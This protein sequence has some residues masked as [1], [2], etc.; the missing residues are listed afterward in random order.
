MH[1]HDEI[2][3]ALVGQPNSGKST[4]FNYLTGLRQTIANYPGVTVMKKSGHYHD[5][6]RRIEVVDLPGTYSLTSYS[7]EERV[8]RDFLLLERPEAVVVVLDAANLRR[9][10]YI[11][12]QL[13]ELRIP[14]IVCLN[15]MDVAKRR[16][17]DIDVE[18]LEKL[19]GVPVIPT[20]GRSGQGLENLRE[21]INEISALHDHDPEDEWRIDYGNLEPL[22]A[23][24]ENNLSCSEYLSK[25]FSV[26]WL[27][28]KLLENDREARR[29]VQ[30]HVHDKTWET[31]LGSCVVRIDEYERQT[32]DSPRKTI[33]AKRN[34]W[35]AAI[36]REVVHRT[37]IPKRNS[38]R[39]DRVL[40]HPLWGIFGVAAVLF[41]T[42]YLA[43]NIS[44]GWNWL[45]WMACGQN[46]LEWTTP[47]AACENLFDAWIPHYLA[48][49]PAL[50]GDLKSLVLDGIVSGIG[51]VLTFAPVIFTIFL[52]ISILEQSGY[53]AR[54]I[55]VMD[56]LMRIFGL[57]GQSVLPMILGGG[58]VGGCAV[59][60]ILATR[61]M[62]EP[63]E[64]FLT[65]L[66]IPLMNCGAK[67]PLYGL[68][69]AAFFSSHRAL[70][71]T[72]IIFFSWLL[73]LFS[74]WALGKTFVR[75]PATPL[76]IELPSY[77][78]PGLIE[79]FLAACRQGW[80]FI[81]KAGTIIL[82]INVLLWFLMYYPAPAGNGIG[83]NTNETPNNA[84][85]L[86]GS[87]AAMLGKTLEPVTKFAGFDW[88]DN[89]ALIGGFAAKEVIVC[90]LSTMYGM[91]DAEDQ[92]LV[93]TI[94]SARTWTRPKA[95]ALLVFVM[96]YAPCMATCAVI[97]KETRS[98]KLM[99]V[100]LVYTTLLACVLA[101]AVFQVGTSCGL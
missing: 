11:V 83:T 99:L 26:R 41:L 40:C 57:N 20:S 79:A 21:K 27:A 19:L 76:V 56:R 5:G 23:E 17:L 97:R 54:I 80:L 73:A 3:L 34:E 22:L 58:I 86:A 61:T 24:F 53:M 91:E 67:I 49:V 46:T 51:G 25:D 64:R 39:L 100:A 30:H 15:M 35:A 32:G 37:Q 78:M 12:F 44:D 18:K 43:F 69:I 47:V 94:K 92:E 75:G 96:V 62:R 28:I 81:K 2:L 88:R 38:D 71:M 60:A 31:L 4:V 72:G 50:Q 93:A 74:A 6:P 42:F 82:L 101:I 13:R 7:Q 45:P 10:L 66:V 68:L 16:R 70:A 59:P 77:Q 33:A 84:E 48:G 90:S 98:V 9:H 14:L 55:V 1:D 52:F 95:L 89:I 85:R 63:R 8:T 36:E 65:I 29:I 87:Y